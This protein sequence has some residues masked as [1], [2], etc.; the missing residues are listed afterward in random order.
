MSTLRG[1]LSGAAALVVALVGTNIHINTSKAT[2]LGAARSE[3]LESPLS[4]VFW[5]VAGLLFALLFAAS[6]LNNKGLRILL[7]WTPVVAISALGVGLFGMYS[8][9][10]IHYR[11]G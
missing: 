2:G 8:Y 5:I 3:L 7:F 10:W 4:M 9:M 6:R 1:F 11:A